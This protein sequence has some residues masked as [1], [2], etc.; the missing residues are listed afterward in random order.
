[1]MLGFFRQLGMREKSKNTQA[2]VDG[3]Q[4]H[5]LLRQGLTVETGRRSRPSLITARMN[6]NHHGA[7]IAGCCGGGPDIEK[8]AVLTCVRRF[9][10]WTRA[11][12]CRLRTY[13]PELIARTHAIPMRRRLRLAPA[14]HSHWC[15]RVG[16]AA[17]NTH[18]GVRSRNSGDETRVK[19]HRL[20]NRRR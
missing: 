4:H 20:L 10:G 18:R 12:K 3:D 6:P 9:R 8:K 13:R 14:Q 2:V 5:A 1:M 19:M 16:Y 17:K 15:S 11:A 7:A